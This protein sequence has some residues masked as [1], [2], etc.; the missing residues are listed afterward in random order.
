MGD[1][2]ALH[3]AGALFEGGGRGAERQCC[4][5]DVGKLHVGVLG[6]GWQVLV[7]WDVG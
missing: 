1:V 3:G 5:E 2:E 4:G 6:E 7:G